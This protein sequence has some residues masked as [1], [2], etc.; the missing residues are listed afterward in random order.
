[1]ET[2]LGILSCTFAVFQKGTHRLRASLRNKSDFAKLIHKGSQFWS[3]PRVP[4]KFAAIRRA[5]STSRQVP[6]EVFED[7]SGIPHV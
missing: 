7:R 1:M 2:R 3:R 4:I 5:I 6:R